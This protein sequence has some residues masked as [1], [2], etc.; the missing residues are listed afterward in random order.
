MFSGSGQGMSGALA[1]AEGETG[2]WRGVEG[3]WEDGPRPCILGQRSS[4]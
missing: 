3:D 1:Y 4:L 2:I